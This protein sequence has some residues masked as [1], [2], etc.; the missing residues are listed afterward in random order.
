M[1]SNDDKAPPPEFDATA[2]E[3]LAP[4]IRSAMDERIELNGQDA[5]SVEL[6]SLSKVA[7]HTTMVAAHLRSPDQV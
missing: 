2:Y 5:Y 6:V 3:N 4:A 1:A 7:R